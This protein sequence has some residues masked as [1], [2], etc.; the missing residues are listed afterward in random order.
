M[1]LTKLCLK[2]NMLVLLRGMV[3]FFNAPK[4]LN[5]HFVDD[6]LLLVEADHRMV[7]NLKM[8]LLGFELVSSLQI[9]F[10]KSALISLRV[11]LDD[12]LG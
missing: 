8:L 12:G 1:L 6:T 11:Y 2:L 4:V 9:N 3:I 5:L 10:G 7:E